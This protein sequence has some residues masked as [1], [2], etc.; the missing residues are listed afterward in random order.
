M[1]I[2]QNFKTTWKTLTF[3]AVFWILLFTITF[4]KTPPFTA[5]AI[6]IKL[7]LFYIII[8]YIMFIITTKEPTIRNFFI[9][10]IIYISILLF[11]SYYM[12]I[13]GLHIKYHIIILPVII[14]TATYLLKRTTFLK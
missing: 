12:A 2:K 14:L 1:N 11:A 7:Y 8:P 3:I 6:A 13:L 4:H 9:T 10:A 5:A